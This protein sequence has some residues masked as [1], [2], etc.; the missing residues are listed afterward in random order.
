MVFS[1]RG[2][3]PGQNYSTVTDLP[4]PTTTNNL[5]LTFLDSDMVPIENAII[6]NPIIKTHK[7]KNL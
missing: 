7:P 6:N 1:L 2:N 4:F 3:T 5:T